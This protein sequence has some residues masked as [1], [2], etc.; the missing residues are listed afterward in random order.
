[1]ASRMTIIGLVLASAG[2]GCADL[3]ESTDMKDLA[4]VGAAGDQIEF[5]ALQLDVPAGALAHYVTLELVAMPSH[6]VAE[7]YHVGPAEVAFAHAVT[8]GIHYD[9][10]AHGPGDDLHVVNLTT[11][12]MHPLPGRIAEPGFI[13]AESMHP[14]QFALLSCP[15]P[16]TVCN[17]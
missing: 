13:R 3:V 10:A 1:M 2:A 16:H 5:R 9:A 7:D 12:P 6:H 11:D 15:P 4:T 14:G 17:P 8:V